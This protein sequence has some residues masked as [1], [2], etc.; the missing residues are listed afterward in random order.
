MKHTLKK[1]LAIILAAA[2]ILCCVL[3]LGIADINLPQFGGFKKL[4]DSVSDF[5]DGFATKAEA[6]TSGKCGNNLTWTFNESTGELVISGTGEMHNY[7]YNSYIR[8]WENYEYNIKSITIGNS[9]TRIGNYAFDNCT[10]LTSITIPD[11]VTSIGFMAFSGCTS[12]IS[13]TVDS[14]NTAYSSDKFGVLFNKNKTELIQYPIG[15]ARTDYTIPDSVISIGNRA[16]QDCVR[17]T[18]IT[19]PDSVT[20]IWHRAFNNCTILSSITIPD[21]VIGIDSCAF[22][23]CTGLTSVTIGNSVTSIGWGAF[24]NCASLTSIIIPDSVTSIGGSAF[25]CCYSLT[26]VTIPDSVVTIIGTNTFYDCYSLTSVT[27]GNS[28]TSIGDNVFYNCNSLTNITIPDSVTSIGDNA[29]KNCTSLTSMTIPDSVTGIGED[30]FKNCTSLTSMTIPDNV[31]NIG[32]SAFYGCTCLTSIIIH[33]NVKSIK[34]ST[35]GAC[36]SLT[37]ITIPDS[38]TRIG[39]YAFKNCTSL[40]SMTIPDSVT[41]IGEDAFYNCTCLTSI[42]IPDNVISIYENAFYNCDSLTN[43]TIPDSVTSIGERA[44]YDCDS[45]TSIIIGNSVTRIGTSA[46]ESCTSLINVTIGNSV[47]SI[48]GGAFRDCDSL[49]SI[50]IPESVKTI[51]KNV[52]YNCK[53]IITIYYGGSEEEWKKLS[54]RPSAEFIYYN[55]DTGSSVKISFSQSSYTCFVDETVYLSGKIYAEDGIENVTFDWTSGDGVEVMTPASIINSDANNASFSVEAKGISEGVHTVK[56]STNS[57][58][59]ASCSVEV[60]KNPESELAVTVE[61]LG[62][63]YYLIDGGLYDKN[64]NDVLSLQYKV[65]VSNFYIAPTGT[66]LDEETKE[67]LKIENVS[68]TASLS[69]YSNLLIDIDALDE[70]RNIGDL[71][72]NESKSV[73]VEVA[74]NGT[75]MP[76]DGVTLDV[77]ASADGKDSVS[78]ST[79][80]E[81]KDKLYDPY[82]VV[83]FN[84][85]NQNIIYNEKKYDS[86]S[87]E[88]SVR[89][90]NRIPS[91]FSGNA[92]K[93]REISACDITVSEIE[94]SAED[95][96][97]LSDAGIRTKELNTVLHAGESTVITG[98]YHINTKHK[99][100]E[101][102]ESESIGF[103]CNVSTS[104]N[105]PEATKSVTFVNKDCKIEQIKNKN[106]NKAAEKTADA[107]SEL[108]SHRGEVNITL[109]PRL[110]EIFTNSEMEQ[111]KDYIL[112]QILF[113]S[114]SD[115]GMID[116]IVEKFKEYLNNQVTKDMEESLKN[117]LEAFFDQ[118]KTDVSVYTKEIDMDISIE[119]EDYGTVTINIKTSVMKT[120]LKDSNIANYGDLTYTLEGDDLPDGM[121]DTKYMSNLSIL[122]VTNFMDAAKELVEEEI[123]ALYS[124]IWGNDFDKIVDIICGE[125]VNDVLSHTDYKS[126]KGLVFAAMVNPIKRFCAKCP[127]DIFVYDSEGNLCAAV[128]NDVISKTSEKALVSVNGSEKTVLL[129]DETYSVV[130]RPTG[131]NATMDIT[132]EEFANSSCLL[133]V[134]NFEDVPLAFGEHY[135]Q[136]ITDET[137]ADE[138]AYALTHEVSGEKIQP[139]SIEKVIHYHILENAETVS[140]A[141]CNQSSIVEGKCTI[142]FDTVLISTDIYAEC[143]A[144]EWE[145]V[146]NSSCTSIGEKAKKCVMCGEVLETVEIPATGHTAGTWEKV[147][148]PTTETEGKKVKKCTVCGLTL[149]EATIAKLPKEPAKDT[150]VVKNPST[151]TISYG[152]AIILHIDESKIPEGGRVEWTASNS[153]FSYSANGTT[154]TISPEKSG[155]TTFTATIYDTYGNPVSTDEQTMTS[156]AG[157]FDKII[158]FF[159]KLFGLTKTIPQ[160]FKGIH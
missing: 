153:N 68:A 94:I 139:D 65:T 37:S 132:I 137:L 141:K 69:D 114:L 12:L 26:S 86:E 8:P 18:S 121:S 11:S 54:N 28:V 30:A 154:C 74:P 71:E 19:I 53:N 4:A 14:A 119:T 72:Y 45:L 88:V 9:V 44:F 100:D 16:F 113:Q 55:C 39:D 67:K 24:K 98:T 82:A 42:I 17:L 136:T 160:A 128:E 5:F 21:S 83:S 104:A 56:V 73:I 144:G 46:F 50:T 66:T 157:F 148:E 7:N 64:L 80:I 59:T 124:E 146:T 32:I 34:N 111:I 118:F 89:V 126:A 2:T 27:I 96:K 63:S 155:D 38:V 145:V 108:K 97:L 142:C 62:G 36:S 150:A 79:P 77:T 57:G 133:R 135:S 99:M 31:T 138:S 15:N 129:L 143:K 147:L 76:A 52:F 85:F 134:I 110:S 43:V 158:A 152:D 61:P 78:A 102:V 29:F 107:L 120:D 70:L 51:G 130:F 125:A 112:T 149:E 13:I 115:R 3:L 20:S 10:S 22:E 91:S 40:T 33:A 6:A 41:G 159:K 156:K 106:I 122:D 93:L 58:K 116:D 131:N 87:I 84:V 23:G 35:F 92:A 140:E 123:A 60:K 105:S 103:S 47:T 25:E 95:S 75:E 90:T 151:S 1:L 109:D 81:I 48:G 101:K 127:V 117:D 49:T